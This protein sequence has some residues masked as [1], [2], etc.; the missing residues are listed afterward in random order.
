MSL[1]EKLRG[2]S[3]KILDV[4]DVKTV[5]G[6]GYEAEIKTGQGVTKRCTI[7]KDKETG[8]FTQLGDPRACQILRDSLE[9]VG[10]PITGSSQAEKLRT[11]ESGL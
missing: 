7:I 5:Y 4:S 10:T 8:D 1:V 3:N 2:T 6:D 9:S 11:P